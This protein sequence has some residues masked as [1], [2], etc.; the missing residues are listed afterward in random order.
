LL[1]SS[2]KGRI[3]A[4]N[5]DLSQIHPFLLEIIQMVLFEMEEKRTFLDFYGFLA[6]LKRFGLEKPVK[7]VRKI[8]RF[9]INLMVFL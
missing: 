8:E 4:E 5:V 2:K 7:N 6:G 1:D 9:L 3:S